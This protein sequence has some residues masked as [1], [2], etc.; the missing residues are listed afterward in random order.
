MKPTIQ[1]I[2]QQSTFNANGQL[3]PTYSVVFMVGEHGPFTMTFEQSQFTVTN[4][5]QQLAAFAATVGQLTT[6]A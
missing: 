2:T 4:V 5:Q 3:I 1:R 6:T